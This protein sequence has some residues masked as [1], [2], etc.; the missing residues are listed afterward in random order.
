MKAIWWVLGAAAM[1]GATPVAATE[2]DRCPVERPADGDLQAYAAHIFPKADTVAIDALLACLGDPDTKIRDGFAFTL[3]SAGLRGKHVAPALMRH[4]NGRLQA[5]MAAPDDAQG[6]RRPFAALA[7]SEVARADRI[8]AFLTDAE[9]HSLAES[10]AAY[11]HG[12]SDYRGFTAGEAWRHGV[13]HGADLMLQLSLNPRLSRADAELMLGAIAAQVAPTA[14]PYYVHGEPGRLAAP[15][16]YLARRPDI[17]DA[18]WAAWFQSRYPDDSLRWKDPYADDAGLS[19]V[20][21][22][23]AFAFAIYV[24]ASESQD[25]Q[26]RRLAP[27]AVGLIKALP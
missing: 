25:P 16:L 21:N 19:A 8:E 18:A 17:D 15:I 10:G 22:S 20:H 5:M 11:L 1:L 3:W 13:A 24:S 6:F 9:L 7:L 14:S 12:V 27:L 2:A 4:A 26:I 23:T